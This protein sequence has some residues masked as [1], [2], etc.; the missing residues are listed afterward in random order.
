MCLDN[1]EWK[2]D[3]VR[4]SEGDEPG[5]SDASQPPGIWKHEKQ[6]SVLLPEERMVK[7][8]PPRQSTVI[9]E[10]GSFCLRV[11]SRRKP[12][13]LSRFVLVMCSRQFDGAVSL[14]SS[15]TLHG[16]HPASICIFQSQSF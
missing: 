6:Q 14:T 12:T 5:R 15:F 2:K 4:Y 11:N 13:A 1:S 7:T 3:T 8:K 10:K 9:L 16:E